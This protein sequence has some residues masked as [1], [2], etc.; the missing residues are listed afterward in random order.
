MS[1]VSRSALSVGRSSLTARVE[2]QVTERERRLA[3]LGMRLAG[4]FSV[5]LAVNCQL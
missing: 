4:S 1:T 2:F 3:I 5:A